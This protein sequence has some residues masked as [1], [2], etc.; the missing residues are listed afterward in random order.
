[1]TVPRPPRQP[2]PGSAAPPAARPRR[3]RA[4]GLPASL[5]WGVSLGGVLAL[6]LSGWLL[7]P[8]AV[9]GADW[10]ER[11]LPLLLALAGW[12]AANRA[13][14]RRERAA[15]A[16]LVEALAAARDPDLKASLDE[17]GS[18][19][20]RL[21][22]VLARL[23]TQKFGAG[24]TGR[25]LYQLPWYLVIGAPGSGKST[26]LAN[27]RLGAPLAS[28][29][30]AEPIANL[31][32]T[33][34][35][36][37]WFTDH[38]VLID[39]AGRY[40]T[41]DS[42]RAVDGR[43]WSGL[44]DLLKTHRP[45]QPV[46]GV[47]VT[48][49]L[50]DLAAWSDAERHAHAITI[51]QRL[52]ELRT[53]LGLRVPVHVVLTKAD[54]VEGFATFF[55]PLDRAGRTQVWG[56]TFPAEEAPDGPLPA[57]HALFA[58]LVRRLDERLLDRLHQEPD[59]RRRS[60]AFAFPLRIAELETALADLVDTAF[61]SESGEEV[62]LLRGIHLTSATQTDRPT[63]VDE[64]AGTY[65]LDRLLPERVFPE[66]GLA[67]VDRAL[68]RR[69]RRAAALSVGGALAAGLLLGG[70]WLH[71]RDGN[72]ALLERA[73][74]AA[75]S[76]EEALRPLGTA[77]RS[78]TRVDDTDA[79]A[80]LPVLDGLRALPLGHAE[81]G[82][83][84]PPGLAGGL[85]QGHRI[86]APAREV[87]QRAL[88]TLFLARIALRLEEQLRTNWARPDLLRL[89]LRAYRMV[90]G[91]EP[92]DRA[93]LAEWLA[94]DWQ[95]TLP[96]PANDARRRALGDH[97]AALFEAGFAP[98]PPDDAL[99]ARAGEV[100]AQAEPARAATPAP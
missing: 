55:D 36:D 72:A 26:A 44:L 9:P 12:A 97:L 94:I 83:W 22:A 59:I 63:T 84:A 14:D 93:Y 73:D 51:R 56:M 88:R 90:G 41:Q 18:V 89:A 28:G 85:Y 96:G 29:D 2:A 4:A 39:T 75:R 52:N 62:P 69:Q 98:V 15:N 48:V 87:Y 38:A 21:D 50:T 61:A 25:Y 11:L 80:I 10:T 65:F 32:G 23:K 40:T 53:H 1:M 3:P 42:R 49:S 6:G 100:L 34:N 37:W 46:N 31:G 30:I 91:Q 64:P 16:R 17:L 74:A 99:V 35:C 13:I 58:D 43:V 24:L 81:R 82:A 19:R 7:V 33:R 76:V 5:R 95:R 60:A 57:F 77:P 67:G 68:E 54:L 71:S 70:F 47:L 66:A 92:M 45:R 86:A 27:A 20:E 79:A 78:L 8:Q